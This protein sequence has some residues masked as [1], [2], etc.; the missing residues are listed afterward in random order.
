MATKQI[1]KMSVVT[2]VITCASRRPTGCQLT[3]S[4]KILQRTWANRPQSALS[5]VAAGLPRMLLVLSLF[6]GLAS[7]VS[8]SAAQTVVAVI[9]SGV[10][11]T[12][13][14]LE[15]QI[16]EGYDFIDK[17]KDPDDE[18][19]HGTEMAGIIA[20]NGEVQ[21]VCPDCRIMPLKVTARLGFV[22]P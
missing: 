12:H 7:R 13:P 8:E 16:V 3:A 14:D 9:D 5:T 17:D 4:Y 20:A 1:L 21:G 6:S 19:G 15:D 10:D 18:V 11:A 2:T 22:L